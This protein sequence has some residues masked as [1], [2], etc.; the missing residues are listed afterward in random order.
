V[1]RQFPVALP[2]NNYRTMA[3]IEN[4]METK[5]TDLGKA[6]ENEL[7]NR[8]NDF[9]NFYLTTVYSD[10]ILRKLWWF[11]FDK[12]L[13]SK[14]PDEFYNSRLSFIKKGEI[15]S[16][17]FSHLTKLQSSARRDQRIFY[18]ALKLLSFIT[19]R[20]IRHKAKA[21]E[22]GYIIPLQDLYE[23]HSTYYRIETERESKSV[24]Y[25]NLPDFIEEDTRTEGQREGEIFEDICLILFVPPDLQYLQ[26]YFENYTIELYQ[27]SP[28]SR[29]ITFGNASFVRI[30][31]I[32]PDKYTN[33]EYSRHKYSIS[34]EFEGKREQLINVS[35]EERFKPLLTKKARNLSKMLANLSDLDFQDKR[36]GWSEK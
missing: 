23:I 21:E 36:I 6:L 14:D 19:D 13:L 29:D 10:P 31:D 33:K 7:G 5:Y 15:S 28:T 35:Q 9:K 8:E 4:I 27:K 2:F 30:D 11:C 12:D 26:N 16:S 3:G 34:I 20:A 25:F 1:K 17:D 18:E 22:A 32:C 24:N